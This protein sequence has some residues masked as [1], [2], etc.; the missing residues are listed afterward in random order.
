MKPTV[1]LQT[2]RKAAI[3]VLLVFYAITAQAQP[4]ESGVDSDESVDKNLATA[5]ATMEAY[6]TGDWEAMRLN[7]QKNARIYGLG[8]YDSLTVDETITYWDEGR[9]DAA[10]LLAD[11]GTWLNVSQTEGPK[12]GDWVY[13][14]GTNTISY[15]DGDSVTFP[16]HIA[17]K[18][19]DHKIIEAHFYYDNMKIIRAMGFALSPPLDNE[20]EEEEEVVG[21][22]EEP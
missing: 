17:L 8:H 9:K 14:W 18:M 10:P 16:Y 1:H 6:E 2:I 4:G 22:I 20:D 5:K 19:Q 21:I 13:H 11:N 15:E 3:G 7:L 12:E